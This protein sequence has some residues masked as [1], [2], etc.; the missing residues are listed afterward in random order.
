MIDLAVDVEWSGQHALL[1]I[2]GDLLPEAGPAL[3]D[4]LA[5]VCA[6][7]PRRLFVDLSEVTRLDVVVVGVLA[8]TTGK[9]RQSG[10]QVVFINP[11]HAA[12]SQIA[13]YGLEELLELDSA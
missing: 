3:E 11:S 7:D 9:L 10:C 13:R 12:R 5:E 1:T 8:V 6:E 4:L 2:R